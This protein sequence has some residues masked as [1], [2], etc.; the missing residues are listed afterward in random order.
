MQTKI[1]ICKVWKTEMTKFVDKNAIVWIKC[2]NAQG[3][4]AFD[5]AI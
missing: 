2:N 4:L 3:R 1:P 5:Y